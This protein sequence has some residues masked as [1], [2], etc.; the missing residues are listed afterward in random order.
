MKKK[1]KKKTR[2]QSD[3]MEWSP[4]EQTFDL[5]TDV[6]LLF[7]CVCV[8]VLVCVRLFV[9]CCSQPVEFQGARDYK[10]LVAFI[11]SGGREGSSPPEDIGEDVEE[12]DASEEETPED[13]EGL[14]DLDE[15]PEEDEIRRQAEEELRQAEEE[16]T[17]KDEL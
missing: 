12:L 1:K 9:W 15:V 14:G 11:E 7:V 8:G 4:Q 17:T 2:K 10:S 16:A 6:L 3:L 5:K 13:Y